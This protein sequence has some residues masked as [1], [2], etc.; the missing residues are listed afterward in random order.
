MKLD[1]G[2]LAEST[3][4]QEPNLALIFGCA[5]SGTSILGEVFAASEE[6]SY[7]FEASHVWERAGLGENDSHRLTELHARPEIA[8]SIRSWFLEQQNGRPLVVEKCPRNTLR[9][10]FLRSI[11]PEV[12]LI[13]IVR[14]GRDVACSLMPGIGREGW[15]HLKPPSWKRF[16]DQEAGIRRCALVWQETVEIALDDLE[17]VPHFLVWMFLAAYGCGR[18]VRERTGLTTKSHAEEISLSAGLGLACLIFLLLPLGLLG[19]YDP[20]SL[21]AVLARISILALARRQYTPALPRISRLF[22]LNPAHHLRR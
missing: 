10:P 15:M 21:A 22:A 9:V 3:P 8:E 16:R 1:G 13:H 7:A 4:L 19:L 20:W 17:G 14:D 6:V 18:F 12:R 11:F 2:S 5:R